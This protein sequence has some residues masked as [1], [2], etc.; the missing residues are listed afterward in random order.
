MSSKPTTNAAMDLYYCTHIQTFAKMEQLI[1]NNGSSWSELIIYNNSNDFIVAAATMSILILAIFW[2]KL[3]FFRSSSPSMPPGPYFLP[4]VGYLPFLGHD[5][6]HKQFTKMGQTYG[7][8]F[9]FNVGSRVHVIINT[10]ELARVVVRDQDKIF[11]HRKLTVATSVITYGG[12]EMA[13]SDS[14]STNLRKIFVFEVLN[15]KNIE[16][17]ACFRRDA[18]RKTVN[19]VFSKV[20]TSLNIGDVAFSTVANV[21]TN[22]VW[23]N[24]RSDKGG[25]NGLLGDEFQAV[26]AKIFELIS[27]VN[28]SDLFPSLAWFD[29]Q[30]IKRDTM[31]QHKKLDQ[32]FAN[33]MKERIESN[34]KKLDDGIDIDEKKDFLQILLDL[35]DKQVLNLHQIKGLILD[36]MLGGTDTTTTLLVWAMTEIV[37]NENVMKRIQ[38]EL[39]EVVGINN[40][41]EES[42]IQKLQYLAATIKEVLRLHPVGPLL[43][44]RAPSEDCMVGGYIVPKGCFVSMNFWAIHRNPL[45]WDNPL[46]FNP[47]RF[48]SNDKTTNYDLLGNN[49]QFVPFGSGRRMCPGLQL[50]DKM[51]MYILAS[52]LHSFDWRLP[53]GEKHDL[54]EKF[55]IALKKL[56]PLIVIPSQRLPNASLYM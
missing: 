42:H 51:Q 48:M 30:G 14:R 34:S 4:I 18:V 53:E 55:G 54:S 25:N 39:E 1:N 43:F 16:A 40:I 31:V 29:L 44:P 22:I 36:I 27:R 12:Q 32:I 11:G 17:C 37:R 38:A 49:L 56:K 50:A 7:P 47:E 45:Y 6:L 20:G 19:D 41:V 33:I 9:K 2:L 21:I 3:T 5:D 46:E 35:K 8:I 24:S 23:G 15:N 13:F 52:L 26:A 28:I 10:P